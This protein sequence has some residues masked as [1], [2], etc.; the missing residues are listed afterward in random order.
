MSELKPCPFCGEQVYLEKVPMWSSYNGITHGYTGCYE[1]D[2]HCRNPKCGCSIKLAK[3]NTIYFE[4]EE[5][6]FNAIKA[7][8]RR[9]TER[10]RGEW[11]LECDGEGECDNLYRCSKCRCKY[12]CQEYDIPNFCPNCGAIMKGKNDE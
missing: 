8:N 2:I 7:W 1:F 5:A 4:E 10:N 6:R 12:G 3:N 11:I 9:S